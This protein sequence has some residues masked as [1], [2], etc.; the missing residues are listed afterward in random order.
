VSHVIAGG[1]LLVLIPLGATAARAQPAAIS[2]VDVLLG[3][4]DV[5]H[6]VDMLTTTYDLTRGRGFGVKE[7][8]P[9]LRPFDGQP[10]A[11]SAVSGAFDVMH[12]AAIKRVERRHPKLALVWSAALVA[13]K[14]WATVNNINAA[15]DIQ[16]RRWEARR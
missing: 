1:V 2:N 12:V 5:L 11:L 4:H 7:G 14:V 10:A 16:R 8:N 15:G 13:V 3:V 6:V 9:F